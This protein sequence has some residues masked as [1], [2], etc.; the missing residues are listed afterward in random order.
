MSEKS[1]QGGCLCG[2]VRFALDRSA[3]VGS[4]ATPIRAKPRKFST[5]AR[6]RN[7]GRRVR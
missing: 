1:E 3:V 6:L 2:A 4:K 7:I 5:L